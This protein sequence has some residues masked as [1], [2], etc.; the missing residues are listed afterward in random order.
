MAIAAVGPFLAYTTEHTN[1][2][3]VKLPS[4]VKRAMVG[5]R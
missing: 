5:L 1:Y 3:A 4:L 2:M